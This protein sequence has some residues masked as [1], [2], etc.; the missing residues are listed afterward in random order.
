MESSFRKGNG[1]KF[2]MVT[3]RFTAIIKTWNQI[4]VET[5]SLKKSNLYMQNCVQQRI[6]L[7]VVFVVSSMTLSGIQATICKMTRQ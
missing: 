5:K 2:L 3:V 1:Y 6:P 7:L 4:K